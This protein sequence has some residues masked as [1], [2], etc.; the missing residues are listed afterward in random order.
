PGWDWVPPG[1]A[2]PTPEA[3][4]WWIRMLY[5]TPILDRRAHE[6]MWHRGGFLVLPPGHPWLAKGRSP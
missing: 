4:P 5:Q 1:G 2:R 6:L 3:M